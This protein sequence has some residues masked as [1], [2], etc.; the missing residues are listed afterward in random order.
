MGSVRRIT[1][2]GV[3]AVLAGCG[4]TGGEAP[5]PTRVPPGG[6][7]WASPFS[8]ASMRIFPLTHLEVAEDG[9][10]MI[11]VFIEFRD[12]WSDTVKGAG[13]LEFRLI[14][15]GGPGGPG[16]AGGSAEGSGRRWEIDLADLDRNAALYD[17]STQTYR[18]ALNGLP[19]WLAS[20]MATGEA[21]PPG[22][23]L[24]AYF[25]TVGPGGE[26]EVL[27]DRFELGR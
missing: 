23:W 24:E 10:A 26:P 4:W 1:A 14:G 18:F 25:R 13:T 3:S 9:E 5:A 2:A 20:A 17:P 7:L 21:I 15:P 6:A 22:V 11:V 19:G 8:P 16:G 27:R 12:Q